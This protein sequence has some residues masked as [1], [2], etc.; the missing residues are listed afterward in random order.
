ML[1]R[2]KSSGHR[3]Q[4]EVQLYVYSVP[5]LEVYGYSA[6]CTGRYSLDAGLNGFGKTRPTGVRTTNGSLNFTL[7]YCDRTQASY[8]LHV[9][10]LKAIPWAVDVQEQVKNPFVSCREVRVWVTGNCLWWTYIIY[11]L[12]HVLNTVTT[13]LLNT[14]ITVL[15]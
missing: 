5:A 10:H 9:S 2:K 4:E 11:F 12:K 3:R 1:S 15:V 13:Q 6:S 14:Y 8:L 7:H